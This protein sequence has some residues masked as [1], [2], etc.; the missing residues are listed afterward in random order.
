MKNVL[1][2]YGG[3]STEHEVSI[4]SGLQVMNALKEMGYEVIPGYI[5][6]GGQWI[7]GDE[8]F[9]KPETYKN[10]ETV[11]SKGKKTVLTPDRS[12]QMV[13]KNF[14]GY[15]KEETKI[16][17]IFPVFHGKNGEDGAV[18]GLLNLLNVP[19]VGCQ[20]T[21][22]A[23]GIDKY[24]C[25]KIA[26]ELGMEVVE[27]KMVS[28]FEWQENK[29]NILKELKDL[30]LPVFVKPNALGSSIGISKAITEVELEN[31]IEVAFCYDQRVLVEKA[32]EKPIEI[33][34][35]VMGNGPYEVS[36]TEQPV[37]AGEVLSFNDKYL[38]S[39]KK[40]QGMA[41]A[42][43]LI[44]AQV[45]AKVIKLVEENAIKFFATIGGKGLARID[46]MMDGEGKLFFNEIN[47]MPGSIAYY[48]WDKK[49]VKITDLVDKLVKLAIDDWQNKQKLVTTFNSNILA[50]YTSGVKGGK[51]KTG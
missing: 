50:G 2:L 6:K 19:Y 30:G 31:A 41:S 33:N 22:G 1:V 16:D 47:T 4:I 26:K 46:F 24:L 32:V 38:G 20:L 27:D 49:G 8:S 18:A 17:V 7:M 40:S 36:I 39:N 29:K 10:L 28:S 5:S 37:A 12:V 44:P 13:S 21:A 42:Q 51:L 34:I 14:F 23:V 45:E 9:L 35:S 11:V 25:K 43:R 15:K 48:L 3:V